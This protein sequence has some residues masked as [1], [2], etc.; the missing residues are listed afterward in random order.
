MVKTDNL[1]NAPFAQ[2]RAATLLP[3]DQYDP[4]ANAVLDLIEAQNALQLTIQATGEARDDGTFATFEDIDA[5]LVARADAIVNLLAEALQPPE[6][7][8]WEAG[9]VSTSRV[10]ELLAATPAVS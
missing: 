9:K 2:D 7:P 6:H 4:I 8:C 1:P 5:A 10:T 3:W